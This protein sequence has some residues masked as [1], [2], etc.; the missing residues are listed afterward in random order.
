[1]SSFTTSG[2]IEA[3]RWKRVRI[4]ERGQPAY[5][6]HRA[7]GA[8][9]RTLLPDGTLQGS[10]ADVPLGVAGNSGE[11]RLLTGPAGFGGSQA[12]QFTRTSATGGAWKPY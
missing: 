9:G 10:W 1:M 3:M 5:T 8:A 12:T 7:T 11:L 6:T 2:R 4:K